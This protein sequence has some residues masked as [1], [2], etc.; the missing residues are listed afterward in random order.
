MYNRTLRMKNTFFPRL[1][2]YYKKVYHTRWAYTNTTIT[3]VTPKLQK[4]TPFFVSETFMKIRLAHSNWSNVN[5][6][7]A[8]SLLRF[9]QNTFVCDMHY[10]IPSWH[11]KNIIEY[12]QCDFKGHF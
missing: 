1:V 6:L 12:T 10:E 11:Y 9:S 3:Q 7:M 8:S 2:V 4:F 5:A